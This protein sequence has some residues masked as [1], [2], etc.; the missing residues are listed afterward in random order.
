MT[1]GT[2]GEN[3]GAEGVLATAEGAKI[4]KAHC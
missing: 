1:S 4:N 2:E 3:G